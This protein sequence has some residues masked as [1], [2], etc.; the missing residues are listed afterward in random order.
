M[1]AWAAVRSLGLPAGCASVALLATM[2]EN[3]AKSGFAG[4]QPVP[5]AL[6]CVNECFRTLG[7][8]AHLFHPGAVHMFGSKVAKTLAVEDVKAYVGLLGNFFVASR[9]HPSL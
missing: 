9:K 1:D 7:T 8:D 4:V 2:V 5:E 6:E 3:I